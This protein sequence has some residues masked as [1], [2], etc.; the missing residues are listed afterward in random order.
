VFNAAAI[1]ESG[2]GIVD[3][4]VEG[5]HTNIVM[6]KIVKPGLTTAE[7]CSRL[8]RVNCLVIF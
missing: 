5:V 4:N 7:F 8:A 2:Q 1:E 6:V 3:V